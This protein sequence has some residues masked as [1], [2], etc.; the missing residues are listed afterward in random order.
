MKKLE[1]DIGMAWG[2]G[3]KGKKFFQKVFIFLCQLHKN[4]D[5]QTS[6]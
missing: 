6:N 1:I 4:M 5:L 2:V 3:R